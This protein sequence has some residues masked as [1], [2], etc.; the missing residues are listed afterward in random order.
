MITR[1]YANNFR[2]L[3]AFKAEFE[4][5]GVLCGPNGAGKS[6][7][8]DALRLIRNLATGDGYLGGE[9]ERDILHLEFTNWNKGTA[10]ESTTQEFELGVT[11][12]GHSFE[13]VLHIEQKANHEKPRIVRES[14]NCDK[15][16]LFDRDLE[17]VRF[18]KADGTQTG[19]PLDWR[20]AALASIQ[21]K[22][23]LREI[24]ILQEAISKLL[25]LRPSPR[26]MEKESK[27]ESVRPDL[28]F[29]N[30]TS[31]YRSLSQEQ[32][33]TDAL[34]DSLREVWPDFKSFRLV[35]VGLN[36][37]ALKLRFEGWNDPDA[38]GL[39]FDQ[40]SDGEKA[41]VGLYMV[42]T[43]LA[44]GAAQTVLIDEPDNFVGLPELQP[45]VLALRE[46]LDENH[47]AIL[48]SHHPEILSNAGEDFGRY[49][50]RDS[51]TSPTRIGPLNVPA[52]LS[53]GEAIARGWVRG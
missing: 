17:G 43:A 10:Q 15:K 29:T 13:Y 51:H 1:L 2:C 18:K 7:V 30:L 26:G 31:W 53:A 6:S 4:S 35:D 5:F 36:T 21:P 23:S 47:Q 34:R 25:I 44:T 8:F 33:W 50:W 28:Y 3:V 42:R 39:F 37:K 52:G 24:A 20:Q 11:A 45:W 19:F 16:S 49:L 32:E 46:L 41:L 38:D 12:E 27:T 9:G 48:I 22:G 40:L 14:A